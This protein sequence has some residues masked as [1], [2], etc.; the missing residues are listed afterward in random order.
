M[1]LKFQCPECGKGS[2]SELIDVLPDR[3]YRMKCADCE[4]T[5]ILTAS[6]DEEMKKK[7]NHAGEAPLEDNQPCFHINKKPSRF[8]LGFCLDGLKMLFGFN[9]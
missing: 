4:C 6:E 3:R 2:N 9:S 5:Y 7:R 1:V 8:R